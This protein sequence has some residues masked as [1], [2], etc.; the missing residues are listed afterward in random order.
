MAIAPDE[1]EL[2]ELEANSAIG[3]L[4]SDEA[5]AADETLWQKDCATA[6]SSELQQSEENRRIAAGRNIPVIFWLVFLHAGALAAPFFFSW[7][8]F[9]VCMGLYWFSGSIGVCMGYHRLLTHGSFKV[10]K[11]TRWALAFIGGLSGEGCALDWVANHRKHHAHSDHDGDPH[12]PHDG[13]WWAHMLWLGWSMKGEEFEAHVRRWAPDLAKD[14]VMRWIG[15]MFLP[16]HILTGLVLVAVGQWMGGPYMAAS[17]LIWGLF[18]RLVIVLH[19]TWFVN[20]WSH[21]WGYRTYETTDDSRNN[22]LVGLLAFGEGWHNN[23]HAYPRMAAQGH[24][25]WEIDMT[26]WAIRAMKWT[27]LA[28]DVV[29]YKKISDR[30]R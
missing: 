27:G 28:W 11:P 2:L 4:D 10:H 26:Y 30:N 7:E 5:S 3:L 19:V 16:S 17:M 13:G 15:H 14:P 23:H 18:V 25:W 9:A 20:S 21:M 1:T 12:S 8:A 22:W 6:M 24:K 29:D